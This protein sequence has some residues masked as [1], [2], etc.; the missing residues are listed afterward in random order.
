MTKNLPKSPF[1]PREAQKFAEDHGLMS[2]DDIAREWNQLSGENIGRGRVFQ[3]LRQ[4]EAK[5]A[6]GLRE[7]QA[8]FT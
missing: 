5:L 3:I 1:P 2:H 7:F 6:R 8:D 4:A